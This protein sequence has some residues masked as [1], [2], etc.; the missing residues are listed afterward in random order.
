VTFKLITDES[1]AKDLRKIKHKDTKTAILERMLELM[2]LPLE[3]GK[4][5]EGNLAMYRSVRAVKNRYRIIY[6]VRVIL[7]TNRD[8]PSD[9][10]TVI[11][12]VIGIRKDG[13]KRDVYKIAAK[14]LG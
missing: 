10:G 1:A 6:G 12:T 14:R 9:E 8:D 7:P 2:E 5:L 13:D 4:P 11:V 3:Q